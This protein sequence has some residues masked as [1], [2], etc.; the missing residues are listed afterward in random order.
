VGL[1]WGSKGVTPVWPSVFICLK[2]LVTSSGVHR[3]FISRAFGV[4][5]GHV[6]FTYEYKD[7]ELV[8]EIAQG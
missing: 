5:R 6:R 3:D 8:S 1:P 2:Y 7:F 4:Q